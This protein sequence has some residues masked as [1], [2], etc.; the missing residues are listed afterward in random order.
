MLDSIVHLKYN[1]EDDKNRKKN[2]KRSLEKVITTKD[3]LAELESNGLIIEDTFA[4]PVNKVC[5]NNN[6]TVIKKSISN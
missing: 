4:Y 1:L 5:V 3:I 6:K 2:K